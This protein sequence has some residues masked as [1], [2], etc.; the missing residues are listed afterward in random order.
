MILAEQQAYDFAL[1]QQNYFVAALKLR[2]IARILPQKYKIPAPELP[3]ILFVKSAESLSIPDIKEL[4]K[5]FN[6]KQDEVYQG[7]DQF[8]EES[9]DDAE[10]ASSL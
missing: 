8:I 7:V 4:K 2:G 1:G 10:E 6:T 3:E 9:Y 5:W